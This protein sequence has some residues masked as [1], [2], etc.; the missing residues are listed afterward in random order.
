MEHI[1]SKQNAHVKTWRKLQT[2]KGRKQEQAYLIEG[3]HLV[4]EAIRFGQPIQQIIRTP[5]YTQLP[6]AQLQQLAAKH[7]TISEDIAR[8]ISATE[9]PQ[10]IFAV[11]ALPPAQKWTP[12]G[13]RY[14]LLDAVQDPGNVGTMIRTADAAGFDGVILG[15]GTADVYNDKVLRATQGSLWHLEVVSMPLLDAISALQKNQL[16]VYATALYADAIPYQDLPQ[17]EALAFVVGNEGKG[18]STEILQQV[19]QVVYIPMKGHAE[20]LNV[21]IAAA[22]LMF[23]A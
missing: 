4:E 23:H 21:A 15:E 22:I 20:S 17:Q 5:H 10:G 2:A 7:Y 3:T 11:I 18:V 8:S 13:K 16:P 1:Q 9:Q 19:D 12:K 14:L 6:E